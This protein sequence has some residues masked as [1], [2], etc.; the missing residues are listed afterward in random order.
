MLVAKQD[1]SL[2]QG[3]E[4]TGSKANAVSFAGAAIAAHLLQASRIAIVA[5]A[6]IVSVLARREGVGATRPAPDLAVL[7]LAI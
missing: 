1:E 2:R 3:Q 6:V 5:G 4:H 7:V